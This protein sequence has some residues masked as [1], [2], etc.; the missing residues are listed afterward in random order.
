M[1]FLQESDGQ[2]TLPTLMKWTFE[3]EEVEEDEEEE[4]KDEEEVKEEEERNQSIIVLF[5]VNNEYIL[6]VE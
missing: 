1:F 4:M 6:H 2:I 5:S 3:E